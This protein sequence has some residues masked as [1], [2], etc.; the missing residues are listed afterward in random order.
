VFFYGFDELTALERDAVETLARVVGVPVTLSL[1]YEPGRHAF[2]ARAEAVEELR[3]LAERVVELPALDEHYDPRGRVALHHLERSLF[4]EAPERVDPG[5]AIVLLE[6]GGGR[7]EAELIAAEILERVG[8][9]VPAEEIVVVARSVERA[10]PVLERVLDQYGI[11]VALERKVAFGDTALGRGL[12]ALARCA[13][14]PSATAG[15]LVAY[16]R[17]PGRVDRPEV[18]DSLE[19]DTRREG[20]RT[21][22]Q[23]LGRERSG[24]WRMPAIR[25]PRSARRR[26]RCSPR[27]IAGRPRCSPPKRNSTRGLWPRWCGRSAS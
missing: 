3:P 10:A 16:L 21:A 22:A 5:D 25:A 1:N 8:A 7:A 19:R 2:A 13:W 15:D 17:T 12:M 11:A 27:R 9:G 23:A 14:S 4:E 18:V 24:S 6:A 20:L 26:A